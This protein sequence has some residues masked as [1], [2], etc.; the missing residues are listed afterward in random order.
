MIR[1]IAP[2]VHKGECIGSV[3]TNVN[4]AEGFARKLKGEAIVRVFF[5]EKGNKIDLV[6]KARA[7]IKDFTN[8]FDLYAYVAIP[9]K[10][11]FEK[12][13]AAIFQ[14]QNISRIVQNEKN[15]MM[16]QMIGAAAASLSFVINSPRTPASC[17]K[18]PRTVSMW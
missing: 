5:Y 12:T 11:F 4:L 10:D 17:L 3:E 7:D 15:S 1:Y 16:V 2:V 14:R 13:F 8:V 6:A 18:P 9:L